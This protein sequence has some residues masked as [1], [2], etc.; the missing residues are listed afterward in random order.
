MGGTITGN[1]A[2][3]GAGVYSEGTVYLKGTVKVS[4]NM[5]KDSFNVA[6]N[7]LLAESGVIK[8]NGVVS[9]SSVGVSVKTPKADVKVVELLDGVE[10]VKLADVL[11]QFTYEGDEKFKL[12]ETG[13]LISTAEPPENQTQPRNRNPLRNQRKRRLPVWR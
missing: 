5:V 8:V 11:P 1:V 13:T 9:D 3:S 4:E 7:V 10:D 2:A 6:S 12:S